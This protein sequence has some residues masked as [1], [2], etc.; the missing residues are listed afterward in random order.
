MRLQITSTQWTSITTNNSNK[1]ILSGTDVIV[2]RIE[3][4]NHALRVHLQLVAVTKV[5]QRVVVLEG[6]MAAERP[7]QVEV[8]R[9]SS[10]MFVFSAP[11]F[12]LSH[13]GWIY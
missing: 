10:T 11:P 12:I 9:S 4:P 5:H 6:D 2:C 3:K 7:P 13:S 8:A 1:M